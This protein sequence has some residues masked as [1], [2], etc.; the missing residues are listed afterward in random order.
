MKVIVSIVI[1]IVLY[2]D[3]RVRR[4]KRQKTV[5]TEEV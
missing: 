2:I 3:D 4:L 5:K 1:L